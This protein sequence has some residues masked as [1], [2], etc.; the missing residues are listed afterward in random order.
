MSSIQLLTLPPSPNNIK[1]RA[2]LG[3]LGLAFEELPQRPDD[4]SAL[5]AA[6]GQPLTPVMIKDGVGMFDSGAILRH[7]HTTTPGSTLFPQDP[8]SMRKLESWET[9][10]RYGVKESIGPMYWMFFGRIPATAEAQASAASALLAD[11][12][13]LEKTLAKRPFLLGDQ[14]CAADFTWA[15]VL[16]YNVGLDTPRMTAAP[17]FENFK[18]FYTLSEEE[19]PLVRAWVRNV[20]QY[21]AWIHG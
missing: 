16:A 1:V 15:G 14:P 3:Y 7:L 18:E 11:T 10:A 20:L 2:A 21:D 4:R 19:R 17:F 6:S 13:A 5:I 9:S 8:D 12:A